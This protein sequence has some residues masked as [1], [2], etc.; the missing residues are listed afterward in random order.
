[1]DQM[2][3]NPRLAAVHEV[4]SLKGL[5][6]SAEREIGLKPEVCRSENDERLREWFQAKREADCIWTTDGSNSLLVLNRDLCGRPEEVLYVVVSRELR[7]HHIG[8][9]LVAAVQSHSKSLIAEARNAPSRAMLEACGFEN[10]SEERSGF[11]LL[12]WFSKASP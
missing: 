8:T 12:R 3:D 5:F 7:G 1:M 10:Q 2:T 6:C 9:R 4:D 11:P